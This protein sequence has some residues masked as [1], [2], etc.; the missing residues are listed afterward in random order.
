MRCLN[1]SI[2]EKSL[3]NLS[4]TST[5]IK[6]WTNWRI[7]RILARQ[8][9][10]NNK[11]CWKLRRRTM[12]FMRTATMLMKNYNM[13]ARR[14]RARMFGTHSLADAHA[15]QSC[16][17]TLVFGPAR[18]SISGR[19]TILPERRLERPSWDAPRKSIGGVLVPSTSAGCRGTGR[20]LSAFVSRGLFV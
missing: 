3:T 12:T 15:L 5:S 4:N 11:K 13:R 2:E 8:E 14:M 6:I 16:P 20:P 9:Q 19:P 10:C 7:R 17:H 1:N 18:I